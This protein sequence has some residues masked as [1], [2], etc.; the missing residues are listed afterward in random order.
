M[1][2]RLYIMTILVLSTKSKEIERER[3]SS[4]IVGGYYIHILYVQLVARNPNCSGV[5]SR[6]FINDKN[7]NF[8]FAPYT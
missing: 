5:K 2:L 4:R 8:H 1:T 7:G 6:H 3:A